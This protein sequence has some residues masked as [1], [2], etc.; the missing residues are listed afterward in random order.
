VPVGTCDQIAEYLHSQNAS[1]SDVVHNPEFLR[2]GSAVYDFFHPD[3]IVAGFE[4]NETP[5]ILKYLFQSLEV[6]I[7]F[8]NRKSAELIKYAANAFLA[9]K[10]SYIN[11]MAD[12][13]EKLGTNIDDIAKGIGADHRIGPSFL[14]AGVGYGGSCFPKDLQALQY[15]GKSVDC[16][17]PLLQ[18]TESINHARPKRIV[19]K[20]RKELGNLSGKRITL[21]GLSFKPMTDDIRE[22]ASLEISRLCL[23]EAANVAAYDPIV[24]D[25]HV[26]GVV[27]HANPY[28]AIEGSDAVILLTEWDAIRELDWTRIIKMLHHPLVID[29]RNMLNWREMDQLS[30]VHDFIYISTGRPT[31]NSLHSMTLTSK[32]PLKI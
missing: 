9:M 31:I 24:H 19:T 30:L 26:E 12:L 17:L 3:R 27:V 23:E 22:A 4:N 8:S 25:F 21:L 28:T 6:D 20:L 13:S 5:L 15:I 10:I 14:Q 1:I 16:D 7:Q 29:C 2:Q 11:M 32:I 18:A